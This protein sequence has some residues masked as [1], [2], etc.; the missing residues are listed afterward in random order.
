[1]TDNQPENAPETEE[2][3]VEERVRELICENLSVAPEEVTAAATF[4]GDLNADSLDMVEL[5]MALEEAFGVTI[6]EDEAE[7]I[8][9]VGD[10][11]AFIE[12]RA[13]S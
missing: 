9:T 2:L 7:R 3:P 1:M 10:A 5:V 12:N 13:R 6:S 4:S 11:V 8:Q